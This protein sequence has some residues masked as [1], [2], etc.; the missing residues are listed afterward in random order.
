MG[1]REVT[2]E[3]TATYTTKVIAG[4]ATEARKQARNLVL[5]G[6]ITPEHTNEIVLDVQPISEQSQTEVTQDG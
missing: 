2:V 3:V 1:L 6:I 5:L 4:S